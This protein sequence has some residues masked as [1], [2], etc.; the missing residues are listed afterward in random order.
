MQH[1]WTLP[2]GG[3]PQEHETTTI[4]VLLG[5]AAARRGS[6]DAT[7]AKVGRGQP[8]PQVPWLGS[9]DSTTVHTYASPFSSTVLSKSRWAL[10]VSG[11]GFK[12]RGS[13]S[14]GP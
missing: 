1:A 10:V 12:G 3:V 8:T 6:M 13:L 2:C 4:A 14:M 11:S 9:G 7:V 5:M